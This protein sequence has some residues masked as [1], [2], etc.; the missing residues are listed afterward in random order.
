[1]SNT[2]NCSNIYHEKNSLKISAWSNLI[3]RHGSNSFQ[4]DTNYPT[5]S[6]S[7]KLDRDPRTSNVQLNLP[8]QQP[9]PSFLP[10]SNPRK[11]PPP[12]CNHLL[13]LALKTVIPTSSYVPANFDKVSFSRGYDPMGRRRESWQVD[14]KGSRDLLL[15]MPPV[16]FATLVSLPWQGRPPWLGGGSSQDLLLV[17]VQSVPH[18]DHADHLDHP[19]STTVRSP[20]KEKRGERFEGSSFFRGAVK[21]DST[22]K[23][24]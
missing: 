3:T 17:C 11:R 18:T 1:M 22:L 14:G 13:S 12:P 4:L 16:Q 6:N 15:H 21:G 9:L 2:W 24:R 7:T 8:I 23:R 20:G 5:L 10:S 19:P